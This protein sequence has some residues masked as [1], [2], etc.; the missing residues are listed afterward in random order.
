MITGIRDVSV[1]FRIRPGPPRGMMRSTQRSSFNRKSMAFRSV[2]GMIWMAS[3]GTSVAAAAARSS[4]ASARFEWI[5]S[6]PPRRITEFPDLT[7]SAA[8]S[9]VTLKW[10]FY[11]DEA[12]SGG[13]QKTAIWRVDYNS[14][15]ATGAIPSADAGAATTTLDTDQ[16]I[17]TIKEESITLSNVAAGDLLHV[18]ISYNT[19]GTATS[20]SGVGM[21]ILD[22]PWVEVT[23]QGIPDDSVAAS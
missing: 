23:V 9:T 7:H 19:T 22:C 15:A 12:Q 14:S 11:N 2:S 8:A 18:T 13:D 17:N 6:E 1:T 5:A 16:A 21:V 4:A 20:V 3:S 10:R